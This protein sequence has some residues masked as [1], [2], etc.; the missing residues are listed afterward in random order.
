M[1]AGGKVAGQPGKV[2]YLLEMRERALRRGGKGVP[3]RRL[4][5]VLDHQGREKEG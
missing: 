2:G 5:E 1:A 4:R 3:G